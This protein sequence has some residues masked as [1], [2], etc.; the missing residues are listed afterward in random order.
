MLP[1]L[2]EVAPNYVGMSLLSAGTTYGPY[3]NPYWEFSWIIDGGGTAECDGVSY[4]LRP[5]TVLLVPPDTTNFYRW[6]PNRATRQ[7]LALFTATARG[8]IPRSRALEGDDVVF[9]LFRHAVWLRV[10]RPPDWEQNSLRAFDH[11]LQIFVSGDSESGSTESSA[12]SEPVHRVLAALLQ[13]WG[14]GKLE[15]PP[16]GVLAD[17]AGVTR[18]HL[19]RVFAREIGMGPISALRVLRVSRAATLLAQSNLAVAEVSRATGFTNEFHF[20][21]VFKAVVGRSPSAFRASGEIGIE[22]PAPLRR[23]NAYL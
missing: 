15:I 22:L 17:A 8:A 16:L 1:A 23:F 9:A 7:G 21:R 3:A 14:R 19:C 2:T 12:F 5:G 6:I 10:E 13:H 18:E 11:A 4:D 20:S